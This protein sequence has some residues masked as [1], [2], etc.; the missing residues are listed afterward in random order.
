MSITHNRSYCFLFA[1]FQ[2]KMNY[3]FFIRFDF[4]EKKSP[5]LKKKIKKNKKNKKTNK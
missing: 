4:F 3:C 5:P 2:Y 1:L